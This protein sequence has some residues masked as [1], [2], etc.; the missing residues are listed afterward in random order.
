MSS[1]LAVSFDMTAL[2]GRGSTH[3]LHFF[4]CRENFLVRVKRFMGNWNFSDLYLM[5]GRSVD[6]TTGG[7]TGEWISK[8]NQSFKN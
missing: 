7:N 1:L 8:Q 6:A 3:K 2:P 4:T 5:Y